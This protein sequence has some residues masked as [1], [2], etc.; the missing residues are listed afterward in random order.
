MTVLETAEGPATLPHGRSGRAFGRASLVRGQ[1]AADKGSITELTA[2]VGPVDDTE[3]RAG[4]AAFAGRFSLPG[5]RPLPPG[6]RRLQRRPSACAGRDT[7][8]PTR[9]VRL[10]RQR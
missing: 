10:P 8:F 5:W 9:E 2:A 4:K 7:A 1:H 3:T 6:P